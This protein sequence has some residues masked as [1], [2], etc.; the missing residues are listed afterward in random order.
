MLMGMQSRDKSELVELCLLSLHFH[1]SVPSWVAIYLCFVKNKPW[2]NNS[3]YSE[4]T[5]IV[6]LLITR[7]SPPFFIEGP[8]HSINVKI[9][10][11]LVIILLNNNNSE[12]REACNRRIGGAATWLEFPYLVCLQNISIS[13]HIYVLTRR[14][15]FVLVFI[16]PSQDGP[17]RRENQR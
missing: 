17:H 16:P 3:S 2:W 10:I 9:I 11:R 8:M 5:W 6:L 13:A 12:G 4:I 7:F 15:D 14:G 1:R